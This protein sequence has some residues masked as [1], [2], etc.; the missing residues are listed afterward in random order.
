MMICSM[1]IEQKL[2]KGKIP[3]YVECH[4]MY[5]LKVCIEE[6]CYIMS[7]LDIQPEQS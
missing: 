6:Y 4:K 2:F 3:I 5:Q 1:S 7:G